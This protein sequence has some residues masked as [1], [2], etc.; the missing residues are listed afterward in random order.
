VSINSKME[1]PHSMEERVAASA[2]AGLAVKNGKR[3]RDDTPISVSGP[4]LP[5]QEC[6]SDNEKTKQFKFL[7]ASPYFFYRDFSQMPDADPFTALTS[8]GRVPNFPAKMHSILSRPDLSD[9]VTWVSICLAC[10]LSLHEHRLTG[11]NSQ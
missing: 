7:K 2:V 1:Y 3:D 4:S 10:F 5:P 8:P 9:I 11:I 6:S